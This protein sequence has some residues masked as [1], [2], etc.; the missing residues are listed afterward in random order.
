[1]SHGY[2]VSIRNQM[3]DRITARAGNAALLRF[4]DGVQPATGGAIT[5]QVKLAEGVCGTPF[6][7]AAALA[8]LTLNAI[9]FGNALASGIG[10]W[11]RVVQ[12]DGTTFVYDA[13]ISDMNL[14]QT[15]FTAGQPVTLTSYT[16]TEGNP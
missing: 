10:T 16:I 8:V 4:F 6:A 15:V 13:P 11:F 1:M 12:S 3:L 7:P 14:N 2:D 9:T 5:T